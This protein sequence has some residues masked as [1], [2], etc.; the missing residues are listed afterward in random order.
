MRRGPEQPGEQPGPPQIRKL[1]GTDSGSE[2]K[3]TSSYFIASGDAS[4][5]TSILPR[6]NAPVLKSC[7]MKPQKLLLG[8]RFFYRWFILPRR[9]GFRRFA[10]SGYKFFFEITGM[11]TN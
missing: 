1:Q 8:Y 2:S 10:R 7:F 11:I 9:Y 3:F 5:T 4:V 6:H